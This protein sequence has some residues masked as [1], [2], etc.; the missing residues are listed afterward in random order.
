M[1]LAFWLDRMVAPVDPNAYTALAAESPAA[2]STSA[3][4]VES[5]ALGTELGRIR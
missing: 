4:V 5:D 2:F 1:G 3:D